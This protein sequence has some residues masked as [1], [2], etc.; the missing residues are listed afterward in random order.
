MSREV[1]QR[2]VQME[3]DN[4]RFENNAQ[5]TLSTLNKLKESLN[6]GGA[7]KGM[8]EVADAAKGVDLSFLQDACEAVTK[9][10]SLFGEISHE[11]F[12]RL[13][14]AIVDA[15]QK[16]LAFGKSLTFDQI[17]AGWGKFTDKAQSVRTIMSA[18]GL[19]VEQVG[20]QM[21]RLNW[22]TDETSA[23][24]TDM[25]ANV[26]KF[27]NAGVKL[28]TAVTAMQGI[29]NWGYRSGATLNEMSR[30]MYNL[31]QALAVGS[32]KLMDWKSIENANMATTE[33]KQ[34][35]IDTAVAM[36]T[37]ID[38]GDGLYKT[39]RGTEVSAKN[40]NSALSEGW[41][42][43]EVLLQTLS[44]YGDFG[45]DLADI[46]EDMN[47]TAT[48]MMGYVEDYK[49]EVIDWNEL[50]RKTG[51]SVDSLKRTF[52][53]MGTSAESLA[54]RIAKTSSK[55]KGIA[56][57]QDAIKAKAEE[58]TPV[59]E[60]AYVKWSNGIT[61]FGEAI[62]AT[63]LKG[64]ELEKIFQEMKDSQS[65]GI[66]AFQ[67]AQEYSSLRDA[68]DATKDAVSTGWMNV[69]EKMFG[70]FEQAKE[71]WTEFGD[72]LYEAFAE[73][74]NSI[75]ELMDQW[76]FLGGRRHLFANEDDYTGALWNILDTVKE[77]TTMIS[78]VWYDTFGSIFDDLE[79]DVHELDV[80]L[81]PD[82]NSGFY[83]FTQWIHDTTQTIKEFVSPLLE[84]KVTYEKAGETISK[85]V[86]RYNPVMENVRK[87]IQGI[88]S[89]LSLA[90]KAVVAVFN[91]IKPVFGILGDILAAL[92]GV[93]GGIGEFITKIDQ[94]ADF[95]WLESLHDFLE[96]VRLKL[97]DIGGF[98]GTIREKVGDFFSS[99]KAWLQSS[100]L[101]DFLTNAWTI[102]KNIAG[103]GVKGLGDALQGLLKGFGKFDFQTV[104]DLFSGFAAGGAFMSVKKF[105]DMMKEQKKDGGGIR[106]LIDNLK[107]LGSTV[108]DTVSKTFSSINDALASFTM[109]QKAEAIKTIAEGVLMLAGA[110]FL[111]AQI[112]S[113][114][115]AASLS[116]IS[117]LI[118]ELV[119]AM[120]L[121]NRTIKGSSMFDAVGGF[122]LKDGFF[123]KFSKPGQ[124]GMGAAATAMIEMAA[125]VG[126]LVLALKGLAKLEPEKM[127]QGLQGIT[128]LM[129][130]LVAAAKVL[131]TDDST[132]MMKGAVNAIFF[133]EA[134]KIL[135]KAMA[136]VAELEPE[137][138]GQGLA[139]VTVLL[140][141]L[142][143][144]ASILSSSDSTKM[145]K[146][147]GNALIFA[148][149]IGV[150]ALVTKELGKISA[151]EF[152]Q[153]ITG[154]SVLIGELVAASW[155]LANFS[156]EK[157]L[158]GAGNALIFAAAIAI[159]GKV[160][161][162]LGGM[163]PQELATGLIGIA[164]AMAVLVIGLNAMEGT[165]KGSAA[166]I[167]AATAL[168]ILGGTMKAIA[169][170]G[171]EGV[172]TALVGL[173][174]VFGV[175]AIAGMA[176]EPIIPVIL[177]LGAALVAI[178]AG[179]TL[180]GVGLTAIAAGIT[181][182]SVALTAGVSSIITS[183]QLIVVALIGLIPLIVKSLAAGLVTIV[184]A[185]IDALVE[186]VPT[187][188]GG[189]LKTI[190]ETL[191]QMVDYVPSIVG[192]LVELIVGILDALADHIP[193]L[194]VS[195][196][197]FLSKLFGAIID[198]FKTI[199]PEAL[200][201]A[202]LAVGL[203]AALMAAL[204]A[205]V[206]LT[207]QA[208]LGVLGMSMVVAEM[209]VLIAA[210]GAL[211]KI[212]GFNDLLSSGGTVLEGIGT[213][214]GS[215]VGGIV[216]GFMSGVSSQFPQIGQDLSDFMTNVTP[217]IEG[218]SKMDAN[219]LDGVKALAETILILT[220]ADLLDSLTSWITGG[221]SLADFGKELADFAPYF[222]TYGVYM[223][224]IDGAVVE[225]SAN[226][227]KAL[228][229]MTK[230]LPTEGGIK[231]WIT[232]DISLADFGQ[233]LADFGPHLM[234]YANSVTGLPGDVIDAS[235]AAANT[236]VAFAKD[237]PNEG[238]LLGWLMGDNDIAT[239]GQH[240]ADFG[241]NFAS[242]ARS[243][244]GIDNDVVVASVTAAEA[245]VGL[246]NGLP[247]QGVF[248]KKMT[249]DDFGAQIK[250]FGS[251]LLDYSNYIKE[252][253][254]GAMNAAT[255]ELIRIVALV[256]T[257]NPD[258]VAAFG[259]FGRS[260][261][262]IANNGI[263]GFVEAFQ[264]G[265]EQVKEVLATYMD[266]AIDG[267]QSK[268]QDLINKFKTIMENSIKAI[269]NFKKD[270]NSSAVNL[271][272]ELINGT[273]SEQVNYLTTMFDIM[274]AQMTNIADFNDDMDTAGQTLIE[275]LCSGINTKATEQLLGITIPTI[276]A[277]AVAHV[278]LEYDNF[279]SV[280]EYMAEGMANGLGS[281]YSL[282][283]VD[284]AARNLASKA[285]NGAKDR[286]RVASPSKVFAW[287]GEMSG[288]GFVNG[289]EDYNRASGIAGDEMANSALSAVSDA[290]MQISNFIQNG[291]DSQPVIRPIL[292]LSDVKSGAQELNSMFG[293]TR[294]TSINAGMGQMALA[295]SAG[296]VVTT[297]NT[298]TFNIY[299]QP[300][301]NAEDLARRINKIMGGWYK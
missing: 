282:N 277:S 290:I 79:N 64:T 76:V 240:L 97:Q 141:E 74:V 291:I 91:A 61:D 73:P 86:K 265:Y 71:I 206:P 75:N 255:N 218:A 230:A 11:V 262:D 247:E 126:I 10:F 269:D 292:D 22:Y 116:T 88:V 178:G 52:A 268:E 157:M 299:Q 172:V 100:G 119:G 24:F 177:G 186:C 66:A 209:A 188:V 121:L 111:I 187:I 31:S 146:G 233:A 152:E 214:I 197:N 235:I 223:S 113:E 256:R 9:R 171:M 62:A 122:N 109:G 198:V 275:K 241:S 279:Y 118:I 140:T 43:S 135:A 77:I 207:A 234:D 194:I 102:L 99:A 263:S 243:V 205:I 69:F 23:A 27:T 175:V 293:Y 25:T 295:T 47:M 227:A 1:D 72:R 297:N 2:V 261:A 210:I 6:F 278:R 70:N 87:T 216:G 58:L 174:G 120:E 90:K 98:I 5:K 239:F 81:H 131:S 224:G 142:V 258:Q 28:D 92:L 15:Q 289:L 145:M 21:D 139:G 94:G 148:A 3:F 274:T 249:F 168:A 217:F 237:I 181:A 32:V 179:V 163:S 288:E 193:T 133:A 196:V 68:I 167:V 110:L 29:T 84:Y 204:A 130:E 284:Q 67:A 228:A 253:D 60:D 106:S 222:R 156:G 46:C 80:A 226:A 280:G 190:D 132:K 63:G 129:V 195:I 248:D 93:T 184:K 164:G 105:F 55:F 38:K 298:P 199:E 281:T 108:K 44:K 155:F 107:E 41:F 264:T 134:I 208:M 257:L 252:V 221:T 128:V 149:A 250:D 4:A 117:A 236:I 89:A 176:M 254:V 151:S 244:S 78:D 125:A 51:K 42:S 8:D 231:S 33:F 162:S 34:T 26:G 201:E 16:L 260:L 296:S 37:L 294:A 124:S 185:L 215:F 12:H 144:S 56:K 270:F 200:L 7:A 160:T 49:N 183:I 127:Q 19:T 158:K 50:S 285:I 182:L 95:S 225:Q 101:T 189:L 40:F 154:I 301:E 96:Q 169:G 82:E 161:Q 20:E 17:N 238:G 180:V 259:S 147:A 159:L 276:M 83:K 165:L 213:A 220:A 273:N 191:K 138:F 232:G 267:A 36:G 287:L 271:M 202:I 170:I 53:T 45:N 242:Y 286:L 173:A 14:T 246:A 300:G 35:A 13:A 211:G 54:E 57:D 153:G 272:K 104:T 115:L 283:L 85:T 114:K 251:N 112:P 18:T 166:M 212:P 229:E 123:G 219:T 59:L 143:V 150:L 136:T 266:Y 245:L 48:Q 203:M 30:A 103:V 192:S 65:L 137:K 39:L